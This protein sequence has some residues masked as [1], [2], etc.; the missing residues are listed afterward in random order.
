M[1]RHPFALSVT[2]ISLALTAAAARA[3]APVNELESLLAP[4]ASINDRMGD[5]LA[6]DAS[7]LVAGV[8]TRATTIQSAGIVAVWPRVGSSVGAPIQLESPTPANGGQFGAAVALDGDALCV[9][10]PNSRHFGLPARGAVH[11]FRLINGVW[12][13]AESV[14]SPSTANGFGFAC[15]L[16]GD[17]LAVGAPYQPLPFASLG[18]AFVF[19]RIAGQWV[20]EGMPTASDGASGDRFG[21]SI[22][23]SGDRLVV[24]APMKTLAGQIEGA[25][26]AFARVGGAWSETARFAVDPGVGDFGLGVSAALQGTTACFGAA[27]TNNRGAVYQFVDSGAGWARVER[28]Q[29][30]LLGPFA[31]FGHAL[32]LRGDTLLVGAYQDSVTSLY[33]GAAWVYQRAGATFTPTVRLVG[34]LVPGAVF[35]KGVATDGAGWHAVGES[36]RTLPGAPASSGAVHL[37]RP[38]RPLGSNYCTPVANSTQRTGAIAALGSEV[39]AL[40]QLTL[41]AYQLPNNSFGFFLA[42][43]AQANIAHPGGSQ[44][45]LCLGGSIG[46]YVGAGQIRNTGTAGTFALPLDLTATPTPQGL[47]AVAPGETWNYQ[48]WHRDNVG[49]ATSNFTDAVSVVFQ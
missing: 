16:E 26:Y 22:A 34:S 43:Q 35:G 45:V 15:A 20:Q 21:S 40:D 31:T 9:T 47:V 11:V 18:A 41:V 5:V 27:R 44:G 12:T 24:G 7:W 36:V 38:D 4:G 49:G 46:R 29:P 3:Q 19:R 33:S 23:L 10:E 28:L 6:C 17:V 14:P 32:S 48:A 1:S 37:F 42:S 39:V 25:A 2:L 30:A 8:P 13:H